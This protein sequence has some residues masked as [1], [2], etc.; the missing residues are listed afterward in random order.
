MSDAPGANGAPDA[1]IERVAANGIEFECLRWGDGH[2]LALCLHGFPDDPGSMAPLA[3]RLVDAGF[4]VVAPYMRG[5]GP[6]GP[7]P[8][9]RYDAVALGEDALALAAELLES[10]RVDP[11][12]PVLVGH[13]WGAVAAH[14]A[15]TRDPD[16]FSNVVSMAVPPGFTERLRDH[17]W[18]WLRSWYM[19]CFQL[20]RLP[21]R[22]LRASEF[23]SI[24]FL[25]ATWSPGWQYPDARIRSVRE[26][27]RTGDTVEAALEYY[28]QLD[29]AGA[30][31]DGGSASGDGRDSDAPKIGT[32]TLVLGGDRDGCIGPELFED[33][34]DAVDARCR[35]VLVKRAGH[36]VHVERPGVVADE[37]LAFVDE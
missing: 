6:T 14:V 18:Q 11:D 16:R 32:P 10:E 19:L 36:F 9:G 26:T 34:A 17:P 31:A 23:A 13:D 22:A 33:A 29:L 21:E 27:F 20:P 2:R 12:D 37:L 15:A 25:W 8:D 24:D 4:T 35:V 28:R 30:I 3:D 1:T 5:Y 7:A